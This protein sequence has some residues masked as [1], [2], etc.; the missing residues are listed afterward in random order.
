MLM[1]EMFATAN[2]VMIAKIHTGNAGAPA[3]TTLS[4]GVVPSLSWS[5]GTSATEEM[6]TRT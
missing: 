1:S 4:S 3:A 5:M 2:I 6:L